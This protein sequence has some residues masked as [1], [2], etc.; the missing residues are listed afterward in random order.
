[1]STRSVLLFLL[2]VLK[3]AILQVSSLRAEPG[4]IW[5]T[6]LGGSDND[7]GNAMAVDDSGNVYLIGSTRSLEFPA[8]TGALD[9]IYNNKTDAF[10]ARIDA[11]GEG[12]GY[13]TYLG[14]YGGDRGYDIVVD[15]SGS[16][17][18]TGFTYSDN[19]PVTVGA[20]DTEHNSPGGSYQDVFISRLNPDGSLLLYSTYMGGSRGEGG[21][22]L[23]LCQDGSL[24]V[25]GST[26]S[27][28]FPVTPEAYDT[29]FQGDR[30]VFVARLQA[31][32]SALEFST[33]VG[34]N[35]IEYFEAM[36][37]DDAGR[38]Y[39]VGETKSDDFPTTTGAF[40][41]TYNQNSDAFVF[42]LSAAGDSLE[43]G[44]YIGSNQWDRG[45]GVAVDTGGCLYLTGYTAST[46]FP[47]TFESYDPSHNGQRDAFVVK[48]DIVQNQL[49][50]GTFLG[51]AGD[52]RGQDILLQESGRVI[53]M[54]RTDSEDFP[55][56]LGAYDETHNGETDI[57][58]V[59]LSPAGD[60]LQ[61][62]TFIGGGFTE[63]GNDAALGGGDVIY[64]T[65]S[66]SS[67]DFPVSTGA[68]DPE[69]SGLEDIFAL[70]LELNP[71][72]KVQEI[73]TEIRPRRCVLRQNYPNPFNPST[74]IE[75]I[76]QRDQYITIAVYDVR[77]ALV[78]TLL[79]G[80][81]PAG[82]HTV[83]WNAA[84]QASGMYFC[85]LQVDDVRQVRKMVL[86][87]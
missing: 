55:T 2:I 60:I 15:D 50:Y 57:F 18:V 20:F 49:M 22:A 68:F 33:F 86:L 79:D 30:D 51:G 17:Y 87:K 38:I 76:L 75:Y 34:G 24:I 16:A 1:M 59:Q 84:D 52:D 31:L 28:D 70:K 65:G 80:Y 37:V 3:L 5:S 43:Y 63:Y 46:G 32:G 83:R 58:V 77:G 62:A 13:A 78:T 14:G 54:G 40:D 47:R 29:L 36:T 8:T 67:S 7:Q 56:T 66:T 61:C 81:Q 23:S 19:F 53:V 35:A 25:A 48:I 41:L 26:Q 11:N 10:V 71:S 12:L 4:I 42:K 82:V 39:V 27:P 44:S 9:T 69:Y 74:T 72:T 85:M 6:F 45:T 21:Y 64:V 73:F